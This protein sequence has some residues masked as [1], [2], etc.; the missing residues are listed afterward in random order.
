MYYIISKV[1]TL[2]YLFGYVLYA[3]SKLYVVLLKNI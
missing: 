2:G 1:S 3:K